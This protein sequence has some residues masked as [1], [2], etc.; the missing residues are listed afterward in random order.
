MDRRRFLASPLVLLAVPGLSRA[1]PVTR[2]KL[3]LTAAINKAGRQRMLSQ[4]MAKG[5]LMAGRGV[6]PERAEVILRQS[7]ALFESQMEELGGLLPDDGVRAGHSTLAEQWKP[8]QR[9][10]AQRA[11]PEAARQ[12]Y[13]TN[14]KVLAAAHR[15]TQEYERLAGSATGQ[16]INLSGRQ[17]MLSQRMAKFFLFQQWGVNGGQS[18]GELDKAQSEFS[19]AM[20]R[21]QAAPQNSA[22]I[23]AELG[24][25]GQQW[26]FFQNAVN[27]VDAADAQRAATDV[28]TTSER[29]LEQMD[30]VVKLYEALA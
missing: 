30:L 4:R 27:L 1:A 6:L 15:L 13:E 17:R 8:Y 9:L 14:E 10:L 28:A 7:V 18:K 20:A 22:R 25:A 3:T 24:L 16:L 5:W 21:L 11:S 23:K 19:S 12:I 2:E 29:L 26:V